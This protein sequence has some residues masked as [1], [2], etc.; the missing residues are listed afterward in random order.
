VMDVSETLKSR[1]SERH[2]DDENQLAVIFST[3]DRVLV[4]APA[5]FGKTQTMVSRIAY[6]LASGQIPFPKRLLAM[7]FSVNAA[8]KIRKDV[9]QQIPELLDGTGHEVRIREKIFVSNYH[10]FARLVLRKYG[11]VFGTA[12]EQFDNLSVFDDG[13]DREIERALPTLPRSKASVLIN[14][15]NTVKQKAALQIKDRLNSY[16]DTVCGSVVPNG[17]LPYNAV[18]A[19]TM[20]LFD[21]RPDILEFYQNYFGTLLVDEFQDSNWLSLAVVTKMIGPRS[22]VMLLG[23]SLQRIYGF[24]GAVPHA[25]DRA[26]RKFELEKIELKKNYRF[27][28]NP[29]MLALDANIRSNAEHPSAPVI[30]SSAVLDLET[31][32]NQDEEAALV[33]T[34]ALQLIGENPDARVAILVKQRGPNLEKIIQKFKDDQ[35]SFFYGLFT[36]DDLAYSRFHVLCLAELLVLLS[37]GARLTKVTATAHMEM[38]E[39]HY[40]TSEDPVVSSCLLLL[41][42]F[43][44]RLWVD[45]RHLSD[46]EKKDFVR[47]VFSSNGLKQY[48][49]FLGLPIIVSTVH[50]AK[51]LE[52]DFVILP[53]MEQ[54]SFPNYYG[55]C[56]Q[57]LNRDGCILTVQA[58]NEERFLEELSVFY[59]AVTRA[60]KN[61]YFTSSRSAANGMKKNLSCFLNLPGLTHN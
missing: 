11:R 8:Y 12:F 35:T 57:C 43:W 6:M 22:K 48:I 15:S 19:L 39:G 47:D 54:D 7:T 51:G 20:R 32:E 33:Q 27:A 40:I 61:V 60:K 59:V 34:K 5:G 13:S 23:D 36:D 30:Q 21:E 41:R 58:S 42:T 1:I 24:I 18:L 37:P 52:W 44:T 45:S 4:E 25:L 31:V 9:V 17:F 56:K 50:A 53:D 29:Q 38:V 49:E 55:L 16:C 28:T 26:L 10:G 46:D 2:Q 14:F 3:S